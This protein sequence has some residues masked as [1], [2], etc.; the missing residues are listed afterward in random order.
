MVTGE[1]RRMIGLPIKRKEDPRLITGQ[2]KYTD[3]M[4]LPDMAYMEVLR[5]VHAKAR[6]RGI[7]A[8]KARQLPGVLAVFTSEDVIPRCVSQLPMTTPKEGMKAKT[9]WPLATDKVRYV[10]DAVAAVVATSR[11]EA[12]DALELM[13]VDYEPLPAVVNVERAAEQGSPL[14]H[15]DLGTNLC[16]ASSGSVGDPDE[17]FRLAD[18]VVSARFEEPRVIPNPIEPRAVLAS[19]ERNTGDLTLWDTTQCHHLEREEVSLVLGLPL[20]K[21]RVIGLDVGGGFG[22]KGPT[23]PET[24]LAALFSMELGRPV[25]WVEDRRE[26]F[27]ATINGRGHVQHVE[28]AYRKDGTVLGMRVKYYVDMG[29]CCVAAAHILVST[30]LPA[31]APGM[32]KVRNYSWTS[33]GVYT[34][35][36]PYGP[37]R[38]YNKAEP[39]YML[40]RIIDLI[41][42]ELGMD[43]TD[44]RRKNFILKDEF[45]Y[46]TATGLEYDSGDYEAALDKALNIAGY[47]NLKAEQRRLRAEGILMGIGVATN[48][49]LSTYG[50]ASVYGLDAVPGYVGATVKVGPEG[51]VTVFSGCSPH[52]QGHETTY[53]QII[54]DE[55]GV[56]FDDVEIV[57]G[58]TSITPHGGLGTAATRSLVVGGTAMIK[59]SEEVKAKAGPIAATLLQT[60][61]E[62]VLMERGRFFA[63]DIPGRFVTWAD[64]SAAASEAG[65]PAL[66]ATVYWE[67][68]NW[69]FPFAAHLAV[70]RIDRDT[71]EVVLTKH[72]CVDDCGNVV[73]P[74]VVEG[75]VHGG[76][77]QGVGTAL[78]EEALW[79]ENGQLVTGSFMDYAMPL[80]E[81]FPAF[82]LGRT[83]TPCPD[84]P[85]GAKGA[86][87]S[88]ILAAGPAVVNAVV[89]ALA[90]LGVTEIDMPV[91]SE[92]V[93]QVLKEKGVAG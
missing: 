3:D 43:P 92:R 34:N 11:S 38:G 35:K 47:D 86:G 39:T 60:D 2:G 40:E 36:P 18:G 74:M 17:A 6:I 13:E 50:P 41:S 8:S 25:K 88:G 19:Y 78:M 75:Q 84:N 90:H 83:V 30:T 66:E 48:V 67:P 44:V 27:L 70:V 53:A 57:Y 72:V 15:E 46:K 28:A 16:V 55:M 12:T 42:R 9:R 10:G 56:S 49:E 23:Y 81:E 73:N 20:E 31:L 85:L 65:E 5:S 91:T 37:Y 4:R 63:E 24:Y 51:R 7:D 93:W 68:P 89:D 58:D 62:H 87:E 71:G 82:E 52:G 32:Y 21:V 77:A 54:A 76:I 80:A 59:A 61:P 14:V 79:D 26:H 69:T 22:C 64:M 29:T 45:P 1:I 33:Y